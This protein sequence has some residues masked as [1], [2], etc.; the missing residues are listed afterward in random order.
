[1]EELPKMLVKA[2]CTVHWQG[3]AVRSFDLFCFSFLL[4]LRV[5]DPESCPNV[6]SVKT[7]GLIKVSL[8]VAFAF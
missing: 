2:I 3:E 8:P 7:V 4:F 5:T 1:M 6:I